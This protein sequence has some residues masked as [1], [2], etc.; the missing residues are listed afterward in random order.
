M[1][2]C[3]VHPATFFNTLIFNE[4]WDNPSCCS[5]HAQKIA[6]VVEA[7]VAG[8][9]GSFLQPVPLQARDLRATWLHKTRSNPSS[10]VRSKDES[11]TEIADHLLAK[12][13]AARGSES[14]APSGIRTR[15]HRLALPV[16]LEAI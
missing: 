1:A 11:E 15:P 13:H 8:F 2:G 12:S 4:V 7:Q 3:L 9:A 6:N 10:S 14:L 16:V 5:P